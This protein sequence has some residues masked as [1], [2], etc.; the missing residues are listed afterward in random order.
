MRVRRFFASLRVRLLLLVILAFLPSLTLTLYSAAEQRARAEV[1][2]RQTA[3][4][5]VRLATSNQDQLAEGARQLLV[6]LAALPTVQSRH[7]RGCSS[8]FQ[9]LLQQYPLY[10]NLWAADARTGDIFCSGLPFAGTINISGAPYMRQTI[11]ARGFTGGE[12]TEEPISGQPV[13]PFGCPVPVDWEQPLA[14]VFAGIDLNWLYQ[15]VA[16]AGLP[17]GS[18]LTVIDRNGVILTHYPDPDRWRGESVSADI[19]QALLAEPESVSQGAG[20]DGVLRIQAHKV[21]CCLASGNVYVHIGIPMEQAFAEPDRVLRRNLLALGAVSIFALLAAWFGGNLAVVRE[22]QEL[23]RT[24]KRLAAGDFSARTGLAQHSGELGQLAGSL[25]QMA[26]ALELREAERRANEEA[27]RRHGARTEAL[28][29]AAGRLNA[30]LDLESVLGAICSEAAAALN[31]PAAS[32]GLYDPQ[33]DAIHWAGSSGLPQSSC[34]RAQPWPRRTLIDCTEHGGVIQIADTAAVP[35]LPNADLYRE[36]GISALASAVMM[37]E[38]QLV[39]CLNAFSLGDAHLLG[40]DE[41]ALLRGLADQAALAISNA[42]LYQALQREQR[43]SARLLAK[44]IS[45]QEDERKRIAR[46]LHDDTSQHLNLLILTLDR[47]QA[48]W[49]ASR[50]QAQEHVA[51]GKA[52]A[53]GVLES[54]HRL[55]R[56]LRPSLLDDLGLVPAI[57]WYGEER[58]KPLGISMRLHCHGTEARL[59]ATMETAL[60]RIAQEAITNIA[61]HSQAS[62][63]HVNLSVSGRKVRLIVQDNGQGFDKSSL[64]SERPGGRGLGLRGMRERAAILGGK[65]RIRTQVGQGTVIAVEVPLPAGSQG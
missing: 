19:L 11:E 60:F 61:R 24:T 59:P 64:S 23:V 33:T 27:L 65:C 2:A 6:A 26:G 58:L 29:R 63:V 51:A 32:V 41:V 54:T 44:V 34:A 52:I 16:D 50:P 31:A 1:E 8:F 20:V 57:A 3:L 4:R 43:A 39:G 7:Q 5:L 12:Y 13:L 62:Q 56:D 42:R 36:A 25:D 35:N 30:Q 45:A 40:D 38:G 53:E 14:V 48:A 18:T 46:E 21:L 28:A 49:R 47:A 22:V 15:F 9:T 17:A 10:A 37:H 55:V